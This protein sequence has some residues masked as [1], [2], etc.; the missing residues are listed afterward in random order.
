MTESGDPKQPLVEARQR[1]RK[2]PRPTLDNSVPSPCIG[3]CWLHDDTG[4]CKGCLRSGDEIR[5]WMIMSREQKLQL[6]Q[7]L[8]QRHQSNLHGTEY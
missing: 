8:A 1:R 6:L 3:V 4:L 7:T 5:D 2:K